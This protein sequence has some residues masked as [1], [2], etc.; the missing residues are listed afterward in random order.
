MGE[1]C[2]NISDIIEKGDPIQSQVTSLNTDKYYVPSSFGWPLTYPEKSYSGVSTYTTNILPNTAQYYDTTSID[3][4]KILYMYISNGKT[5]ISSDIPVY[6][7][8]LST[9]YHAHGSKVIYIEGTGLM[10][11]MC[12]LL[13]V[14]YSKSGFIKLSSDNIVPMLMAPTPAKELS[15]SLDKEVVPFSMEEDSEASELVFDSEFDRRR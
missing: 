15:S 2:S 5:C 9:F 3:M 14:Q 4:G 8:D 7:E 10:E 11:L 12:T 1:F 13:K 6:K